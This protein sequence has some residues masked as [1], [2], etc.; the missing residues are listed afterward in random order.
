MNT[1]FSYRLSLS[2]VFLVTLILLLLFNGFITNFLSFTSFGLGTL[3]VDLLIMLQ[4]AHLVLT[5]V[6]LY[7]TNQKIDKEWYLLAGIWLVLLLLTLAKLLFID[8]NALRDRVLG[9]RNNLIYCLPVVYLPLFL[10]KEHL[11]KKSITFLLTGG[12]F[13][14]LFAVFQ[15]VFSSH[16]SLTWLVL[17][18]E[19]AFSF[20]DQDIT[21]P[22]ALM[23]NTI[24]FA[25]FT[26]LLFSL[27][28]SK[29]ITQRKRIYLLILAIVLTANYFTYTRATLVGFL[30]IGMAILVLHTGRWTVHY[31]LKVI[32]SL[33]ILLS[34]IF[35]LGYYF[36][37]TF[38]VKRVTGRELS[39]ISSNEGHF[40][41]I[42]ES[43]L[44]LKEHYLAG[45]GIGSQG[46]SANPDTVIITD[47]YWFQL[48]LENGLPLGLVYLAFY[49]FCLLY[50]L[51]AFLKT[52]NLL[53]K[54]LCL[55]FLGLSVYYYAA[56]FINSAFI[57]RVNFILYWVLFGLIVAQRLIT[58]KSHHA[59]PRH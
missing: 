25:S 46:P 13:L 17:R 26:L 50:A 41:M 54:Q 22:T 23:G 19:G 2:Y 10:Q 33:S 1:T 42:D 47:G 39:T 11:I 55:A 56:S 58:K 18:G 16:L 14:C 43:I 28:F 35:G 8:D 7:F 32:V 27:L 44:Y 30:L 36:R 57:G 37:D 20:Y 40:S 38:L 4:I 59:L 34:L 45:S 29:Y 48:F 9:L 21:R 5:L 12:V 51:Q 24:I 31:A 53:L 3:L 49:L 6:Y 52:K 15:F